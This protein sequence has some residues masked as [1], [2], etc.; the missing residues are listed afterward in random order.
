MCTQA[1]CSK[2]LYSCAGCKGE[3]QNQKSFKMHTNYAFKMQSPSLHP[4]KAYLFLNAMAF[5]QVMVGNYDLM[6]G[7]KLLPL[8]N[9]VKKRMCA[10]CSLSP[11]HH[12]HHFLHM[13]ITLQVH[14]HREPLAQCLVL[15]ACLLTRINSHKHHSLCI[16]YPALHS[17]CRHLVFNLTPLCIIHYPPKIITYNLLINLQALLVHRFFMQT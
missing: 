14:Q 12:S 4:R 16:L 15:P 1:H 8:S 6:V 3:E 10:H 13:S 17:T 7:F 2:I 11:F 9:L 5:L